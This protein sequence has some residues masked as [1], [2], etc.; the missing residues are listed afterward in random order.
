MTRHSLMSDVRAR[1]RVCVWGWVGG[2]GGEK[3]GLDN[4]LL[5][6]LLLFLK[7]ESV[8]VIDIINN[9][10]GIFIRRKLLRTG[11]F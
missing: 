9:V 5:L 4:L 8:R 1:A 11:G 7:E 6:G 10:S 3:V 2:W